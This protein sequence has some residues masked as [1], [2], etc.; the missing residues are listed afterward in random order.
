M[1]I[2]SVFPLSWR[3]CSQAYVCFVFPLN[4]IE[5][6][7]V[8]G[9]V[10]QSQCS[11]LPQLATTCGCTGGSSTTTAPVAPSS[12]PIT[13]TK[14]VAPISTTPAA[15]PTAPATPTSS[16]SSACSICSAG[17]TITHPNTSVNVPN[18]GNFTCSQVSICLSTQFVFTR[19]VI[20]MEWLHI[21]LRLKILL[22]V[23]GFRKVL[24]ACCQN[25]P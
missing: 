6:F 21:Y 5:A 14:P 18:T 9:S 23:E 17:Q 7:A 16:S 11:L 3:F 1:L 22:W 13:S 8:G 4:Q 24:A 19:Q 10:P 15:A 25:L 2:S 12:A 20:H